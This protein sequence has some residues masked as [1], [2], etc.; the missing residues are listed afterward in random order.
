MK[1]LECQMRLERI[2]NGAPRFVVRTKAMTRP[3]QFN[4]TLVFSED[5]RNCNE[6]SITSSITVVGIARC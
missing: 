2:A 3:F 6:F 4:E 5:A 1:D